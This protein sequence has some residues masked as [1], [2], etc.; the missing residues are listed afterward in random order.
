MSKKLTIKG[1]GKTVTAQFNPEKIKDGFTSDT[2]SKSS[3]CAM[4]TF[5]RVNRDNLKVDLVFDT[6]VKSSDR[7]S[8]DVRTLTKTLKEMML[9]A[10]KGKEKGLP[11]VCTVE[12]KDVFY[13]GYMKR[14]EEE[15]TLFFSDGTPAR[16]KVSVEFVEHEKDSTVEKRM[17]TDQCRKVKTVKQFDRLDLIAWETLQDPRL[18]RE[19]VNE[20]VALVEDPRSFP[21]PELVGKH[22]R[23]PDYYKVL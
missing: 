14:F 16:S 7:K 22:L 9:P 11:P 2:G 3:D 20:N 17:G 10:A 18:W 23:I 4:E 12:W 1:N 21:S 19:I 13:K 8:K 5:N 15:F 6:Y